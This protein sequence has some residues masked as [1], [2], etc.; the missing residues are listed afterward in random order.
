MCII[1]SV[2]RRT[3]AQKAFLYHSVA[4]IGTFHLSKQRK[5]YINFAN[6]GSDN[7]FWKR[8]YEKIQNVS[9][10]LIR[11][12]A[13]KTCGGAGVQLPLFL[14]AAL[15]GQLHVPADLTS[16]TDRPGLII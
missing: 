6:E 13:M 15:G 10:S 16:G 5:F 2:D 14:T 7:Y 11:H 3:I 12:H 4:D 1:Q 9:L 8:K